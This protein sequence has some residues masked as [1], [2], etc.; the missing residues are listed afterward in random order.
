MPEERSYTMLVG[1]YRVSRFV[2]I[3][4]FEHEGEEI[5]AIRQNMSRAFL[6]KDVRSWHAFL[7]NP[8][9]DP[10][11][12]DRLLAEGI[13]VE[14]GADEAAVYRCWRQEHVHKFKTM[15]SHTTATRRCNLGC[16]YCI[17]DSEPKSMDGKTAMLV[18]RFWTGIIKKKKPERVRD[19]YSG[20]ELHLN[21]PVVLASA[22]RRFFF[23]EGS[24]IDFKFLIITNGT[25]VTPAAISRMKEVGLDG[26]RVSIAGPSW[27]HNRLRPFRNGGDTYEV[28]M[29][30]LEAISGQTRI[31]IETQ[32]DS[33]CDDYLHVPE[34]LDD[35]RRRGIAVENVHFAPI[36]P[37]RGQTEFS[38]GMGDPRRL[39]FL[40]REAEKRDFPQ[41]NEAPSNG[42]MVDFKSGMTFDTDGSILSCPA[43][44]SGEFTYGHAS[45]GV[46][47]V[48]RYQLLERQLPVKCLE[49]CD[50]L[51]ICNGGCRLNSL[52]VGG[53]FKG[54]DCQY[55]AIRLILSEHIR[56]KTM[57]A[58]LAHRKN[59][60]A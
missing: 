29:K 55:E 42:C 49:S 25:L 43:M 26:V 8:Q 15:H 11:L 44:Q 46:D 48:A 7:E 21:L 33:G 59:K 28:I 14:D 30:N 27:M 38:C 56:Q 19:V 57:A 39:L 51:P 45:R 23:C 32:Y 4:R 41:F 6:I 9:A 20:G 31:I 3:E 2:V 13:L 16:I 53:S 10:F 54:V 37:K 36:L 40:M 1:G 35:V 50:V 60:A 34:M 18:D 22:A 52:S 58:L 5:L 24:G 17:L 47:A 12:L